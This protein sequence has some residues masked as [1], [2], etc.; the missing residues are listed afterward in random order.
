MNILICVVEFKNMTT[1]QIDVILI[2]FIT[3]FLLN[4]KKGQ[5]RLGRSRNIKIQRQRVG[6][7]PPK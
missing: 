2:N 5:K 7:I 1:S 3:T 4:D 6:R